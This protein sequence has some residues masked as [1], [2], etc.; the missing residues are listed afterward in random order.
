[1]KVAAKYE[2]IYPPENE[3]YLYIC[4]GAYTEAQLLACEAAI[5]QTLDFDLSPHSQHRFLERFLTLE[6]ADD[7]LAS[8]SQYLVECA[9]I[10]YKLVGIKPSIVAAAALYLGKKVLKRKPAWTLETETG[11]KDKDLR[12]V[13]KEL[14]QILNTIQSSPQKNYFRHVH[15]KFCSAKFF[16]VAR[17]QSDGSY[18]RDD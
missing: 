8:Y 7:V 5:L 15:K 11:Y 2:E 12:H 16:E 3:D 4:D 1:M 13:A 18:K 6:T 9:A 10:E 17:I 14:C